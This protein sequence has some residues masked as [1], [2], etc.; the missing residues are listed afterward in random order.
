S[1][2]FALF[3]CNISLP[4]NHG[5]AAS[6][7]RLSRPAQRSLAFRPAYSPNHFHDHLHRRLQPFRYLHNCSDCYRLERKL[8][9]GIC[10][11][12]KTVPLHGAHDKGRYHSQY[13][14]PQNRSGDERPTLRLR[15]LVPVA[16][17]RLVARPESSVSSAM[18]KLRLERCW[19]ENTPHTSIS[20]VMLFWTLRTLS[21]R[22]A[23]RAESRLAVAARPRSCNPRCPPAR[24]PRARGQKVKNIEVV[25]GGVRSANR[26]LSPTPNYPRV[27]VV[28]YRSGISGC[29]ERRRL[30]NK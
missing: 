25:F 11:R 23:A 26:Q 28:D 30:G 19:G 29:P 20:A 16:Y 13:C 18:P 24:S 14:V 27:S 10:T 21:E 2:S 7:S 6:T 8:P 22:A 17:C 9:G 4:R 1:A 12:W 15:D 5:G 3:L